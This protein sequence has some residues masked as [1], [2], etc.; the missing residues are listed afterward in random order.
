MKKSVNIKTDDIEHL[1]YINS[2][3]FYNKIFLN[4]I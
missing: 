2:E 3:Y 4:L 1:K